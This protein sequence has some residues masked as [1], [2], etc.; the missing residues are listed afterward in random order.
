MPVRNGTHASATVFLQ[1]SALPVVHRDLPANRRP[2]VEHGNH[3]VG[4]LMG[5]QP[6]ELHAVRERHVHDGAKRRRAVEVHRLSGDELEESSTEPIPD[7]GAT[8]TV[9]GGGA[10]RMPEQAGRD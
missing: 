8:S 1:P 5:E 9:L 4:A 7:K 3:D 2:D 6:F 10:C